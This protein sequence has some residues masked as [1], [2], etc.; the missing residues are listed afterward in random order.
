MSELN[1]AGGSPLLRNNLKVK[2]CLIESDPLAHGM[3]RK[4]H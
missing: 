1:E 3:E 4:G 2:H